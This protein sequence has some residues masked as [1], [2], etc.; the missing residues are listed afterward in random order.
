MNALRRLFE[1]YREYHALGP[2]RLKYMGVLGALTFAA[3]YFIRFTRPNPQ[4]LD[5]LELRL[6]VL[7]A[8]VAMA[9]Q[10]YW[11]A[12]LKR[13]YFPFSYLATLYSLPFFVVYTGLL[14]GG[15]VPAISNGFVALCFL[16][17]LTDWRNTFVML[18][19]GSVAAVGLFHLTHP[20]API[21]GDMLAQ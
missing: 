14:R 6:G 17:L 7:L 19:A 4:P 10:D 13:W 5:D 12:R 2:P 21:P 20:G 8:M 18:V 11:P 15:G 16:T 9:L 3:F 1:H